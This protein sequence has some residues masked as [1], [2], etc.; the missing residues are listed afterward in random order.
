VYCENGLASSI[1]EIE[2][3]SFGRFCLCKISILGFFSYI[4][5]GP[6]SDGVSGSIGDANKSAQMQ[7]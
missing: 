4:K 6:L 1:Y 5:W 3:F 7:A 2:K